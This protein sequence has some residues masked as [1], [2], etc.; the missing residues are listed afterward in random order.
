M[1]V[2]AGS[3]LYLPFRGA[4]T[5]LA[6][7]TSFEIVAPADG[8]LNGI[9]AIVQVAIVTGGAVTVLTGDAGATT[10]L[11]LGVTVADSATKGTRYSDEATAGSATRYV[12]KGTRIQVAFA[13][14]FNGGGALDGFLRLDSADV[15]PALPAA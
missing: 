8:W 10:V 15:S 3:S 9:Q 7:G 1:S 4:A 2:K 6:A 5:E 14:G 13:A 11:G 12:T